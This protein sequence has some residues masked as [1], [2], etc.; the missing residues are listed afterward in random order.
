MLDDSDCDFAP[1][2]HNA[3]LAFAAVRRHLPFAFGNDCRFLYAHNSCRIAISAERL[4]EGKCN[5]RI[6]HPQ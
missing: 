2:F 3:D 6:E 1:M 4:F 5:E